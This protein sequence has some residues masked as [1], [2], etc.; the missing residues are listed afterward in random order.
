M[1][2]GLVL[3]AGGYVVLC[4]GVFLYQRRLIYRPSR[5][6]HASPRDRG[7]PCEDVRIRTADG[8]TLAAWHAP[9]TSARGTVIFF[10]G[11]AGN[12][13]HRI[14][15]LAAWRSLGFS[16]LLPDYRG[17]GASS[18]AP[19]EEGLY[20]DAEAAWRWTTTTRSVGADRVV[21]AGRSLGGAVAIELAR[22]HTPAAL[23]AESTFTRLPDVAAG[24]YPFLPVRWLLCERFASVE[25][26]GAIRCP[27][28][29]LHGVED[30]L[31]PISM[32]RALFAAAAEPKS[33]IETPGDHA[34]G[35][36]LSD[37]RYVGEVDEFLRRV[38]GL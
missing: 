24:V 26:I 18:G 27:K 36:L 21:I 10:H 8:Q 19:T 29:I 11:N 2:W 37:P 22:R 35:G 28:V 3:L 31:I 6:I 32:G 7:I 25:K 38:A 16:V 30:A 34:D 13:S 14:G 20:E 9:Q 15:E 4:A 33:F 23:V 12:I 5:T 17:F 1:L